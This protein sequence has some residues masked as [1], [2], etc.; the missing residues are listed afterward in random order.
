V[1]DELDFSD[2]P[3]ARAETALV[4]RLL[5][6][7]GEAWR[8]SVLPSLERIEQ[9]I[10]QMPARRA[11]P[12]ESAPTPIAP[13]PMRTSGAE[14]STPSITSSSTGSTVDTPQPRIGRRSV[15]VS[16][17]CALLVV[18]LLAGAFYF[19]GLRRPA[20]ISTAP[21]LILRL[22]D[23]GLACPARAFWSPDGAHLAVSAY[24]KRSSGDPCSPTQA[25]VDAIFD[26][27]TG[28][29]L[30]TVDPAA[31]LASLGAQGRA[32]AYGVWTPDGHALVYPVSG[33]SSASGEGETAGLLWVPIDGS[34]PH[35][36]TSPLQGSS[37]QSFIW[38]VQVGRIVDALPCALPPA[39]SYRWAAAGHLAQDRPLPPSGVP[40]AVARPG[41]SPDAPA[42]ILWGPGWLEAVNAL[43]DNGF[44]DPT[45]A[46]VAFDY[47]SRTS[48]WSPDGR[49]LAL[50]VSM[51]ALLLPPSGPVPVL[52][53]PYCRTYSGRNVCHATAVAAPDAGFA[54]AL[55]T[56]QRDQFAELAWRPDGKVLAALFTGDQPAATAGDVKPVRITL[57]DA[58]SGTQVRS[59]TA[60]PG[61][62]SQALSGG[63]GVSGE[64]PLA[65]S[66]D[67]TRL[68]FF[69]N[70]LGAVYIWGGTAL[71]G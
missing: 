31:A 25:G 6:A 67:G 21:Q 55:A 44:P 43:D 29:L 61:T 10:S 23:V 28:S 34:A 20:P 2:E 64:P 51:A 38:D 24:T 27:H 52:G 60:E 53:D 41:S 32:I 11:V 12:P 1:S 22:A 65:W 36:Q 54:Y 8:A 18:A 70:D 17:I 46:P 16:T 9:R 45:A 15:L 26:A 62:G 40:S 5:V 69:A 37:C 48:A 63:V 33:P 39:L 35:L 30:R 3:L 68:A 49:Y 58:L 71:Q 50:G 14:P 42:I 13:T 56:A 4:H 59:L 7:D 19:A 66:P 47:R 57:L